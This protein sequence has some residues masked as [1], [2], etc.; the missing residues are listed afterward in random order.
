MTSQ[1]VLSLRGSTHYTLVALG[2]T[3]IS[4]IVVFIG[5]VFKTR[6]QTWS[7]A[8]LVTDG[9]FSGLAYEVDGSCNTWQNMRS[10]GFHH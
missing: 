7:I 5:G 2:G 3:F 8:S 6:N 4:M 9:I 1:D 10:M